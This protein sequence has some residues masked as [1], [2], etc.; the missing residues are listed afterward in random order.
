LKGGASAADVYSGYSDPLRYIVSTGLRV[1]SG[2]DKDKAPNKRQAEA[3]IEAGYV[4]P[5]PKIKGRASAPLGWTTPGGEVI[6]RDEARRVARVLPTP[7]LVPVPA[8]APP[9]LPTGRELLDDLLKRPDGRIGT[10]PP[11]RTDELGRELL[12]DLL[13]RPR[14]PA[15]TP[16]DVAGKIPKIL[17]RIGGAIGAILYPSDLGDSDLYPPGTA[18]PAPA[19]EPPPPEPPRV[20][21]PAEPLPAP[22]ETWPDPTPRPAD[23]FPPTELPSGLPDLPPVVLL[24]LPDAEERPLLRPAPTPT[25]A[26]GT[27]PASVP[28]DF[29]LAFPFPFRLPT[30]SRLPRIATPAG[31]PLLTAVPGVTQFAT[32]PTPRALTSIQPAGL[33]LP[34]PPDSTRCSCPRKP[35]KPRKPRNECF[36]GSYVEKRSGIQKTPRRKVPCQ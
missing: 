30:S 2:K 16:A 24:P 28:F 14:P 22:V 31:N 32:A 4:P 7:P 23:E 36:A 11:P 18:V 9:P 12:D 13:K 29:P 17:G 1:L 8:P 19:P 5:D 21:I 25:A 20:T 35:R 27:S 10:G 6:S 3:L 34:S 26:P 15:P 33:G